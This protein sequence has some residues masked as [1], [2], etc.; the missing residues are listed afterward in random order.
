[1][2]NMIPYKPKVMHVEDDIIN[3]SPTINNINSY[4]RKE[5]NYDDESSMVLLY[6]KH[7]GDT[8]IAGNTD[9]SGNIIMEIRGLVL[10]SLHAGIHTGDSKYMI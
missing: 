5:N 10:S 1:M 4:P 8:I 6:D 7:L 3:V 9:L 2:Y